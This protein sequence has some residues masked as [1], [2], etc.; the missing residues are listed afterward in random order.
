MLQFRRLMTIGILMILSGCSDKPGM[1]LVPTSFQQLPGWHY[2]SHA[3]VLPALHHTCGVIAKKSD[4]TKM[5]TRPDGGGK[6][7]DWKPL[8]KKLKQTP[9]NN[10]DEVK[11]FV[12][13]HL[14]P[15]QIITE[16]K[17]T[18]MF[19]GY[20]VPVLRGSRT[21]KGPYQTPL[22][23]MPPPSMNK[24]IPRSE[25]A[26]GAL[27]G[28]GLELVYVDDPLA[29]FF[30]EIQGT[31]RI[32]LENGQELRLNYA[33]Q[34]GYPYVGIGKV[35]VERGAMKLEEASLQ[36]IRKWMLAHPYEAQ[37]IMNMNPSYVFFKED[38]WTGDVI[39]SHNVPL[40][41][42][43][44]MAVDKSYISLGTPLW[45][46]AAH[47]MPGKAPLQRLMVAQDVGG[48]IKGPIRGDF[49]WGVGDHAGYHAG[50][51]KSKGELY[52]LLPRF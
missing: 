4:S 3:E 39:G 29:A 46:S 26:A 51:M 19:T 14:T 33:G 24:H 20:F 9:L 7:A 13:T 45:L 16:G 27:K 21:R 32:I 43:R 42:L 10:H 41:P 37:A 17:N 48:A 40:T 5:L 31:G 22:Y 6:A 35:L 15:Y 18:G 12:E 44:S 34:N 11:R 2:D 52:V 1:D 8:C 38:R 30:M 36:G 25:I 50:N 49:Y 28:K 23:R 47:P